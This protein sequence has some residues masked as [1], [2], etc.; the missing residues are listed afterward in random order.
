MFHHLGVAI[1]FSTAS[2]SYGLDKEERPLLRSIDRHR[3]T[4]K[5]PARAA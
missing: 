4:P 3:R 2:E 5:M 1:G